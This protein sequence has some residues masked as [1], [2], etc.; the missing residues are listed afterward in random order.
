MTIYYKIDEEHDISKRR[1]N[2][3]NVQD[4]EGG[5]KKLRLY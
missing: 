2:E 4:Q 5:R 3:Q 1:Q